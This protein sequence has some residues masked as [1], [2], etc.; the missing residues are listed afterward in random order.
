MYNSYPTHT[1]TYIVRRMQDVH[2][3]ALHSNRCRQSTHRNANACTQTQNIY[4]LLV[5]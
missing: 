5:L 3:A 1:H 2:T 4:T